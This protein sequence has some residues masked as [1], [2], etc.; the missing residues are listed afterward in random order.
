MELA[1]KVLSAAWFC[2]IANCS[3]LWSGCWQCLSGTSWPWTQSGVPA[4]GDC[5][6]EEASW[7]GKL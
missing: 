3:S 5:L 6:L 7:W 4:R 2:K 1:V